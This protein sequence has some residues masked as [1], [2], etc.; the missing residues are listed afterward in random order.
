MNLGVRIAYLVN[1]LGPQI[2]IVG[3]GIEKAENLFMAPLE[4]SMRKFLLKEMADKIRFV[5][6]VLGDDACV[7]GAASL[8]LREIFIEA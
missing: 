4:S 3:G 5:P 6:A 8:A 7:K 2:V 1:Q